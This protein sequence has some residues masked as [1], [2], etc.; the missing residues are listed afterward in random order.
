MKYMDHIQMLEKL[1]EENV[2]FSI[3]YLGC[4]EVIFNICGIY[5]SGNNIEEVFTAL[6]SAAIKAYPERFK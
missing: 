3:E 5:A 2:P 6:Y 4:G 1:V